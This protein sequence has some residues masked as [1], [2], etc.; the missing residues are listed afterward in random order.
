MTSRTLVFAGSLTRAV[1]HFAAAH[2]TGITSFAFDETTGKLTRLSE[3]GGVDNPT[4]LALLP[5]RDMLYATSEVFGKAEGAI[6]AFDIDRDTG[7]LT[8]VG[9][10][11]PTRGSLSAYCTTDKEGRYAFV[12]NYAHETPGEQPGRHVVSFAIRDDGTLSPAVSEFT[13]R[14]AGP[15]ADRQAVPHAHCVAVAPDNRFALVTDLGTDSIATYRI[16]DAGGG[17]QVWSEARTLR[18][19]PGS[20]PR[21]LA[22]H[23]D[24][25]NVYL[26]DELDN[27][28]CRLGYDRASGTLRLL[29]TV[30]GLPEGT[31]PSAAADIVVS[32]DGR[33]AYA[34]FRGEDSVGG[35]A[36]ADDG[37]IT[38]CCGHHPAGGRTPRAFT[39]SPSN[40]FLL[41]AAQDS[42]RLVV[43]RRDPHTGALVEKADEVEIGTPMC[44]KAMRFD[45]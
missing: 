26:L 43:W 20:G 12:A 25:A 31:R 33:F 13:H 21:H 37:A 11:H 42:D 28:L 40:R 1:P 38:G 35:Y 36:L 15:R 7:A 9:E 23:P 14:G 45:V 24:G 32:N 2:G 29:Q 10:R 18:V 30:E 17:L 39:L 16:D 22:F 8:A 41:V 34:T 19:A 27:T 6:S 44:V 4:Y 3:T 5:A